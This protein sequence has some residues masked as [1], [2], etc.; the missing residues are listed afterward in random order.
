MT[1]YYVYEA[2]TDEFGS[3][4]VFKTKEEAQCF[5]DQICNNDCMVVEEDV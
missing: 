4:K 2:V 3:T 5:A 1:E